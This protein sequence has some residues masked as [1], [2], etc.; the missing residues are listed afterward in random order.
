MVYSNRQKAG[1]TQDVYRL[2]S[3]SKVTMK[4]YILFTGQ[5]YILPKNISNKYN[6]KYSQGSMYLFFSPLWCVL[7][8]TRIQFT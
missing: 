1:N 7:T 6:E 8:V 4:A 5:S 3:V 2:L